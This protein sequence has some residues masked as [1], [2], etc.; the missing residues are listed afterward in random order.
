MPLN[1]EISED[2][3]QTALLKASSASITFSAL[4]DSMVRVVEYG[5]RLDREALVAA[6]DQIRRSRALYNE[7]VATMRAVFDEMNA[8]LFK[9]GGG[10]A[11]ELDTQLRALTEDFDKARSGN[12]EDAMQA[13]AAQRRPRWNELAGLMAMIRKEHAAELRERFYSRVGVNSTCDTY[14]LRCD[15]VNSGLGWATANDVL[16]RALVAWRASMKQGEPPR[17]SRGDERMQDALTLQ[18]TAAGGVDVERL[19]GSGHREFQMQLPEGG[20][21]RRRYGTFRFRLGAAQAGVYATGTMHVHRDLPKSAATHVRLVRRRMADK[22]KWAI[23][24]VLKLSA[25]AKPAPAPRH[26]LV[27]VHFGWAADVDGRRVAG[28]AD[29]ADPG[30]ARLIQLPTTI[31]DDLLRAS[32]VQAVRDQARNDAV[33][34]LKTLPIG[35]QVSRAP[36]TVDPLRVELEALKRL[37]AEHIAAKRFYRV[38]AMARHA[39]LRFDWLDAWVALDRKRWQ[40][41]V[42]VARRARNRRRQFYRELALDLARSYTAIVIEPLDLERA[43]AKIDQATG[44]RSDFTRKARSGRTVAALHQFESELRKAAVDH[45]RAFFELKGETTVGRC[46][47]CGAMH[48]RVSK[49]DGQQLTCDAC[50]AVADRM[51][52]GA[53]TAW[54]VAS[55]GIQER[56]VDFHQALRELS[57]HAAAEALARKRRMADGRAAVRART[58][59]D[60]ATADGPLEA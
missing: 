54:Q 14:R 5:V 13:I 43:A 3:T 55:E 9:H 2:V 4:P 56:V 33:P 39:D 58:S 34:S 12:D 22:D 38:Q 25:P 8:W 35:L 17:F 50:G 18:F 31:E 40:E 47:H 26:P 45:G 57:Q 59:S 23:Q 10:R 6:N 11:I 24:L 30:L 32:Q 46:V 37:P 20:V 15:A 44:K 19:K 7:I 60:S 27:A 29:A 53:A 36:E 16:D 28:I 1:L 48:V 52:A 49:L 51:R 21:G 41:A 42:G